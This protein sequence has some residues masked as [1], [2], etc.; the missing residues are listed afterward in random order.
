ILKEIVSA[1]ASAHEQSVVHGDLKPANILVD[2]QFNPHVLDFGLARLSR[3]ESMRRPL[4]ENWGGTLAYLAPE[5][6]DG[7]A[8]PTCQTDIY[9]LGGTLYVILTGVLRYKSTAEIRAAQPLLPLEHNPDLPEA[10]QRICLKAM[11]R[12]PEDRY[13][14][15]EQMLLDLTRYLENR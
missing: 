14:T 2:R 8:A 1:I 13:Q 9:A 15:A 6:L 4:V 7:N 11:E 12:L 3:E 10:L 5:L